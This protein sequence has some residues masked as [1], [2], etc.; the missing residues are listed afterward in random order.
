ME[1][2]LRSSNQRYRRSECTDEELIAR[3]DVDRMRWQAARQNMTLEAIDLRRETDATTRQTARQ[4][5]LSESLILRRETD[6][7]TAGRPD[8]QMQ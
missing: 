3:R 2:N 8:R 1:K 5:K 7:K 4:N 6:R